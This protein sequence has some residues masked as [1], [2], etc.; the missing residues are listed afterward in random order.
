MCKS[1]TLERSSANGAAPTD[2]SLK[3]KDNVINSQL[4]K[5]QVPSMIARYT[6]ASLL[7][8][9][10]GVWGKYTFVDEDT[11]PGV[12]SPMH[13][14]KIPLFFTAFYLVSLPL[15]RQIS[16]HASSIVDMKLLLKE[17]MIIYNAA[18]V[19]LNGWMVYRFITA[20]LFNGHP[21]VGDL[22]NVTSGASFAVW[23]HYCDK[24]LEFFDTYFMVLRGRMDQVSFLHV[25]HHTSIAWAW[26]A[27]LMC[28]PGGDAYFGAL[29][30]S[31]IHVMMYSY[32]T[33]SLLK[34][35]CPWKKYLTVC[36]LIQFSTVI[37]YTGLS[38]YRISQLEDTTWKNYLAHSIQVFEMSS[39][40]I[41][42][43]HFYRKT[44]NK[45]KIQKTAK[46]EGK[47]K[48]SPAGVTPAES[49][50]SESSASADGN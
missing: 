28:W 44:Y 34:I 32:Y 15:L 49:S 26:W 22:H 30:N 12:G 37:A 7:V 11:A 14:Y 31:W 47:V 21:F 27:G 13:S 3:A 10:F 24:Y 39:L 8:G 48:S 40:F 41:L 4:S 35:P 33:L 45:K 36:Q 2:K 17:S 38:F 5:P 19:L 46:I 9:M 16:L 23:V 42:F 25:Y 6:C 18:Q 43:M 1:T 20:V 29:L 50:D